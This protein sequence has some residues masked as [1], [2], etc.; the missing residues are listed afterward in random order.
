MLNIILTAFLA[1]TAAAPLQASPVADSQTDQI[2]MTAPA[3]ECDE[4]EPHGKDGCKDGY[5]C[6]IVSTVDGWDVASQC[7]PNQ[8]FPDTSD[9]PL[10]I[11]YEDLDTCKADLE[12][13]KS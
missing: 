13:P 5:T 2:V 10:F 8:C 1:L 4:N 11:T 9:R 3:D 6:S 7:V 12:K